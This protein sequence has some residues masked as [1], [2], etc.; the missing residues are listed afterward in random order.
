MGKIKMKVA[1]TCFEMPTLCR[2]KIM[3]SKATSNY[4]KKLQAGLHN[5]V[6]R[7]KHE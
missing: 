1:I 3:R 2:R 5:E 7:P 6:D 4:T